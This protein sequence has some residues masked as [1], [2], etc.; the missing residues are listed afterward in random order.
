[1]EMILVCD[2]IADSY[3]LAPFKN[4]VGM[5]LKQITF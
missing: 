5:A 4:Q 1:M 2:I 3:V